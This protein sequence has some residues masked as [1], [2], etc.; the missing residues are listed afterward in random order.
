VVGASKKTYF[1]KAKHD[2]IHLID[3]ETGMIYDLDI[4]KMPEL[5]LPANFEIKDMDI[6]IFGTFKK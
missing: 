4:D 6:K 1:E 5:N 3:Q 2:H